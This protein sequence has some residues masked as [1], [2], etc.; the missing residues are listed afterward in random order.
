[1]RARVVLRSHLW[2][3]GL[4]IH[5]RAGASSARRG[6]YHLAGMASDHSESGDDH[7]PMQDDHDDDDD[8]Q[9]DDDGF[10][11]ALEV[12]LD[13]KLYCRRG[14]GAVLFSRRGRGYSSPR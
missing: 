4:L 6:L 9:Y 5:P 7:E 2:L 11:L 3:G 8:L 14:A 12:V 1:M 13:G 10:P